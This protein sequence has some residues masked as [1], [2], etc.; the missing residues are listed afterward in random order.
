MGIIISLS[1]V[2]VLLVACIILYNYVNNVI[3]F[4]DYDTVDDAGNPKD[5]TK[6]YIKKANGIFAMYDGD[7]NML[8]T[9][10]PFTS[11]E[12]FFQTVFGTLID[13]DAETGK[14][15][16]KVIPDIPFAADGEHLDSSLLISVFKGIESK[17]IRT[18]EVHNQKDSFVL[19]RY[20]LAT[21]SVDD[22]SSFV[23]KK[24]PMSAINKDLLSY[25][26]W[27]VGNPMVNSR[28][29]DPEDNYAEYGLL[30]ETRYDEQGNP[31]EYTP[32]YY[33]ITTV[34]DSSGK[35][36][37]HKIIVGDKLIDGS[38]WYI[39]YENANGERRPA[40]YVFKP[41]DMTDVNDTNFENTVLAHSKDLIEPY[42]IYP[43]TNN[44]Y[45]EVQNF[46][47]SKRVEDALEQLV[48]F[49]YIDMDNREDTLQSIHPYVFTETSFKG[50]SPNYD[51]IDG[52]L[53]SLMRPEIVQ[54]AYLR[55]SD[56]EKAAC[57][58]MKPVEQEDGSIKY[59]YD[60]NF[61]ITFD[62]TVYPT[63]AEGQE[64]RSQPGEK[65][66][67]TLYI[68]GPNE[69]G[70][71][72]VFTEIRFIEGV[73]NS[74]IKGFAIDTICEVS[75]S[76]LNFLNY[77]AYDWI[78]PYFS[79]IAITHT[80]RI[81]ILSANYNAT[82]DI[83]RESLSD[84]LSMMYIKATSDQ[85]ESA[86]TFGGM[87]FVDPN[88]YTWYVTPSQ[89][90]MYDS[91]GTEVKPSTGKFEYNS[92]GEQVYVVEGVT[93]D[94]ASGDFIYIEKDFV[95]ISHID[96]TSDVYLRYHNTLFKRFFGSIITVAISDDYHLS[97]E[98][99]QTLLSDPDKHIATVRIFDD[100]DNI[101]V[102]NYYTL[103]ARKTYLTIGEGEDQ[104]GGFYVP[105]TKITKFLND[106][107][108][109]FAG[110]TIDQESH[111]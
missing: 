52:M 66:N 71:Y 86:Y 2:L 74:S 87:T 101:Y 13:V 110:E 35:S 60:S 1:L 14:Y 79:E 91:S 19:Q 65:I 78:Y 62:R 42:I 63:N 37:T 22:S 56:E 106:A 10:S 75:P 67:Q 8:P 104:V 39:Q 3:I 49:S 105:T 77:D 33:V 24:S 45:F 95:K 30:P 90:K 69:A 81:E 93:Q 88:G 54:V 5:P 53:T 32:T 31:Y 36:E 57:G 102:Y 21:L 58:L 111:K 16:V 51:N 108:K 109:F 96:G 23:L 99:E 48:G 46:S 20:N 7:G 9:Y 103:T 55:P 4:T 107:R 97:E 89:I 43:V 61:V 50:Y 64:D 28:L 72:Y 25:L 18:I 15:T 47:F 29:S 94:R 41:A 27:V 40:I 12:P 73:E 83:Y 38:G 84:S 100:E 80:K 76:S 44:N 6:Y 98:D 68:S 85:G 59:V 82:F 26:S 34:P 11:G 92:L 17:N 70:N